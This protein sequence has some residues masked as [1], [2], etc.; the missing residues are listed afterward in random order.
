MKTILFRVAALAMLIF[1]FCLFGQTARVVGDAD[2]NLFS[3]VKAFPEGIFAI[4]STTVA[5]EPRAT[6]SQFDPS[7]HRVWTVRLDMASQ[8]TDFE[9]TDDGFLIVGLTPP[10]DQSSQSLAVNVTDFGLLGQVHLYDLGAREAFNRVVRHPAPT[11]PDFPFLILGIRNQPSSTTSDFSILATAHSSGLVG[12]VTRVSSGTADV[13]LNQ[14][15]KALSTGGFGICGD[16]SG[17]GRIAFLDNALAVT[18]GWAPSGAGIV[19]INDFIEKPS[20]SS[21]VWIGRTAANEAVIARSDRATGAVQWAYKAPAGPN[22]NFLRLLEADGHY[23]A[24]MSVSIAGSTTGYSMIR[25]TENAGATAI[26]FDWTKTFNDG[27]TAFSG[28]NLAE[29]SVVPG[30]VFADGRTGNPQGFGQ[31]DGFIAVT[32]F[33]LTSCITTTDQSFSVAPLTLVPA[34]LQPISTVDPTPSP[35]LSSGQEIAFSERLFCPSAS[36]DPTLIFP[37]DTVDYEAGE[38]LEHFWTGVKGYGGTYR[39]KILKLALAEPVPPTLPNQ[40]LFFEKTGVVGTNFLYDGTLPPFEVGFKYAWQIETDVPF[41]GSIRTGTPI[42]WIPFPR[43]PRVVQITSILP[44]EVCPGD[45][46][47]V[48][49]VL[50]PTSSFSTGWFQKRVIMYSSNP[51]EVTKFTLGGA[52]PPNVSLLGG[53]IPFASEYAPGIVVSTSWANSFSFNICAKTTAVGP[54]TITLYGYRPSAACS[55]NQLVSPCISNTQVFTFDVVDPFIGTPALTIQ[56]PVSGA[57]VTEICSG[58]PVKF[59]MP[60]VSSSAVSVKWEMWNGSTWMLLTDPAFNTATPATFTVPSGVMT[61]NCAGSATGFEIK[62]YRANIT[63]TGPLGK[64]CQYFSTEYTLKICCKLS[65]ATVSVVP[66]GGVCE[67]APFS[68]T[69]TLHSPDLFVPLGSMTDVDWTGASPGHHDQSSFVFSGTAGTTDIIFTAT[70]QHC[71]NKTLTVSGCIPVQKKPKCG[72]IQGNW[73]TMTAAAVQNPL[74][75]LSY[76]I[77]PGDDARVETVAPFDDCII[78]WEF[79]DDPSNAVWTP[80]GSVGNTI[81]NTNILLPAGWPGNCIYY[82]IRCEPKPLAGA[83]APVSVDPCPPCYS[84]IVEICLW[85]TPQKPTITGAAKI[86]KGGFTSLLQVASPE[87]G[88]TYCWFLNGVQVH[89]GPDFSASEAGN[90]WV[91]AKGHCEAV[92]SDIFVLTV[93]EPTAVIS[94]PLDPNACA[95]SNEPVCV[96]GADSF[97]NCGPLTL[98]QWYIGSTLVGSGLTFCL[99][100]GWATTTLTLVIKD[101]QGCKDDAMITLVP[102][103]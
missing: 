95:H 42:V 91:V 102:C 7:G 76:L 60:L 23:Y 43:P 29:N 51:A 52:M 101:A 18:G 59:V 20:N 67:G 96:S 81:Q 50:R 57:A 77:C 69:V 61:I 2:P 16:Q 35:S 38:P 25:F 92:A 17:A 99:P 88:V 53:P 72:T 56:H 15:L 85:P 37:K 97:S 103:D 82:R 49:G 86:C 94:C 28:P 80:V 87:A 73:P 34:L 64:T 62:K 22:T 74:A 39:L 63:V 100:A 32:D 83:C 11:N 31:M 6:F 78:N 70:I 9:Q 48:S 46:F 79:T 84:N 12:T 36:P 4:G 14:S 8:F 75:S 24:T 98:Y 93:C 5:G 58:D 33:E 68:V 66:S 71:S 55:A 65:P 44:K 54:N 3:V 21:I 26:A 27:E 30:L 90:Y 89:V 45:C 40:G 1:P 19:S 10:F 13:Q 41:G 47:T